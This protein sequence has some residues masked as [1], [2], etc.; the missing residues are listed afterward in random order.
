M[1]TISGKKLKERLMSTYPKKPEGPQ[2]CSI[3]G[4]Q[5]LGYERIRVEGDRGH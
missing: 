1:K 3:C 2:T 4:G 5:Y